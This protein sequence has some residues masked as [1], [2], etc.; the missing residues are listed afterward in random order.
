VSVLLIAASN[1]L[2][3]I[4]SSVYCSQSQ[5]LSSSA[6]DGPAGKADGEVRPLRDAEQQ[7]QH[8]DVIFGSGEN[9]GDLFLQGMML[10]LLLLGIMKQLMLPPC[11]C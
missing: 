10:V 7:E 2:S 5:V 1:H 11:T 3:A 9:N 6:M 8:M 4:T